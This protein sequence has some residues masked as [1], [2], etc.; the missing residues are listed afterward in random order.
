MVVE[1]SNVEKSSVTKSR[2]ILQR[3]FLLISNLWMDWILLLDSDGARE[4]P[5]VSLHFCSFTELRSHLWTCAWY[6]NVPSRRRSPY[7]SLSL[8]FELVGSTTWY[9]LFAHL[10]IERLRWARRFCRL[11]GLRAQNKFPAHT[12]LLLQSHRA[13]GRT[14]RHRG[15]RVSGGRGPRSGEERREGERECPSSRGAQRSVV[16]K[17]SP[18]DR[19]LL[20][21][22]S[23]SWVVAFYIFLIQI[24]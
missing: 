17:V 23:Y 16:Y 10:T 5:A 24:I 15:A 9:I 7:L 14:S 18:A 8:S 19:L 2:Q 4:H 20:S 13:R 3:N 11:W 22:N 1:L 21:L 6:S 12:V